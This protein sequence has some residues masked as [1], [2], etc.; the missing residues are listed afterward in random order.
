M[1]AFFF[2]FFNT[3]II[4]N[5]TIVCSYFRTLLDKGTTGSSSDVQDVT[6]DLEENIPSKFLRI[7]VLSLFFSVSLN[8]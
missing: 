1:F 7:L 5:S 3:Q 4:S 8:H 6:I 2:F